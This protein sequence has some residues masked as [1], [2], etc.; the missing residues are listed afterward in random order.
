MVS[1]DAVNVS[2]VLQATVES[3]PHAP[4]KSCIP[5]LV[6]FAP[7]APGLVNVTV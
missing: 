7:V 3:E 1:E 6:K 4:D 2:P 5:G